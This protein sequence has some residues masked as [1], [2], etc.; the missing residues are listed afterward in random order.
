MAQP[1]SPE[2]NIRATIVKEME[3]I[4][5]NL[6]AISDVE[7]KIRF[8]EVFVDAETLRSQRN[9]LAHEYGH[10]MKTVEWSKVMDIIQKS[11]PPLKTA[12]DKALEGQSD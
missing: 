9:A 5:E 11:L 7:T 3:A 4:S 12:L 2:Y 1:L 6:G 10:G 8:P